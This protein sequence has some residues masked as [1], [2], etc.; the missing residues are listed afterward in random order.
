[1]RVSRSIV[2]EAEADAI[3]RVILEDGYLGMGQEVRLFEQELASFLGVGAESI[4]CVSSGTAALHL[5]V[6]AILEPGDEVLVQSL[7][8][9][10]SFQ[11][12]S[13]A[14][15]TPVACEVLPD[16]V[17]IDLDD[18]RRRLTQRTKAIM[19]VHYASN[20]GNLEAIYSFARESGL[21]CIEDAAHAFGCRHRGRLIGTTGDIVCF[22]FDGIK[23][24][25]SGEGGAIVSKDA[26]VM[27]RVRDAR[28]LGVVKDTEKRFDGQRSWD[29]EVI[30]QGYRY[31]MSNLFAAIGRVQLRRFPSEFLPA[32]VELSRRYRIRLKESRL[33][34]LIDSSPGDIVPHIMPVRVLDGRRDEVRVI[35]SKKGVETGIHYKPNHLT[36]FYSRPGLM[37]PVTERIYG[38][39][40]TLPLHPGLTTDDVDLVCDA[41]NELETAS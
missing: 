36:S 8:F 12:I 16:T 38:E 20:P 40:L 29:F 39:L 24:I 17:T 37:L 21:R 5:A 30:R 27:T 18:A 25:T 28:L 9:V 19:P 14:G 4:A 6:Q 11:A 35:L 3:R 22:S 15:A 1:M 26:N 41:L 34:R 13:A 31:H 10:S 23:N 32:R 7:T 2:G 33:V